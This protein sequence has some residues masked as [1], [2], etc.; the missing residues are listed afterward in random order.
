MLHVC[1][2]QVS[3]VMVLFPTDLGP[4]VLS[5]ISSKFFFRARWTALAYHPQHQL[6]SAGQLDDTS[7]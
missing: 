4:K 6:L 5:F 7:N 2:V 1:A 3:M